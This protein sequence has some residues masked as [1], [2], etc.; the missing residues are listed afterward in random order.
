MKRTIGAVVCMA[1][2]AVLATNAVAGSV[3]KNAPRKKAV[4]ADLKKIGGEHFPKRMKINEVGS[5]KA[6]DTYYH[7]FSGVLPKGG[8]HVIIYDNTPKY[9]GFYATD[10]EPT[11]YEEGAVLLDSGDGETFYRIPIKPSGPDPKTKVR[12]P[13]G[14]PLTFVAAPGVTTGGSKEE[15]AAPK[16]ATGKKGVVAEYREW[17][18]VR[19]GKKPIK[20]RA[21]YVSQTFG[22]VTIKSEANGREAVIPMNELSREDQEY[23]KQFKK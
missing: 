22:S 13:E 7:V 21:I 5:V 17:T 4:E 20:A 10:F 12:L 8:Y 2:T 19:R 18:I 23:V 3:K 14:L 16:V 1:L 11:D 15:A 9:L 6:G